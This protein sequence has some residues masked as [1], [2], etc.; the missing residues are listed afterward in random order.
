MAVYA[1]GD[2]QGCYE[3]FKR[4]LDAI[5]FDPEHDTL[6]L[7]GDLVNRGP[8][9]LATLR[10]VRG[11]GDSVITVLGNHDLHLLAMATAKGKKASARPSL[12]SIIDA[13]DGDALIDWLRHRP[14]LH[15]DES[16]NKVLVHAGILPSWSISKACKRA[17]EVEQAL[18]SD[19]Y[20][21]LLRGLYGNKP[22][23][24][25]KKLSGVTRWRFIINVFTR[26]RML[27]LRGGLEFNTKGLPNTGPRNSNPWFAVPHKRA[28]TEVVFGH[29]SA[30]GFYRGNG[31]IGLDTGCVWG[32]SLTALRLD[33]SSTDAEPVS[34]GC[35]TRRDR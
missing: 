8:H 26:M 4:L 9:S 21:T 11:L 13:P 7:T 31:V 32:R 15:F 24:W 22:V 34:I 27:T 33:Q 1:I 2:L 25:N 6:W 14:L 18:R 19:D 20:T 17:A 16:L 23:L 5:R 29:W 28:G 10:L 3:E 35:P 12:R 30:L